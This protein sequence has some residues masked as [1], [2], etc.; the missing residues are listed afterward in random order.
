MG[1][2]RLTYEVTLKEDSDLQ[3]VQKKPEVNLDTEPAAA[4]RDT[5]AQNRRDGG[6]LTHPYAPEAKWSFSISRPFRVPE[7][8]RL[9]KEVILPVLATRGV[10]LE[11]HDASV[12]PQ[13]K[14]FWMN[15]M[16][17]ILELADI[18]I[19]VQMDQTPQ[20]EFEAVYSKTVSQTG[21][22][23]ALAVNF[24]LKRRKS[25][26]F[27]PIVVLVRNGQ[28]PD[29]FSG[30]SRRAIYYWSKSEKCSDK[31][32]ER[33]IRIIDDCIR[34]RARTVRRWDAA[35]N[36]WKKRAEGLRPRVEAL[37]MRFLER[38]AQRD[39]KVLE[40]LGGNMDLARERFK[41]QMET[42]F[43]RGRPRLE[44]RKTLLH[45][46]ALAQI[47]SSN[48]SVLAIG[49]PLEPSDVKRIAAENEIETY[50]H[51]I[52]RGEAD[53][54]QAFSETYAQQRAK[55]H[56]DLNN[57]LGLIFDQMEQESK[58]RADDKADRDPVW[59]FFANLEAFGGFIAALKFRA[60]VRHAKGE[61]YR[62]KNSGA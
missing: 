57:R 50:L 28:S 8:D 9:T 19:F 43:P 46:S 55:I 22:A 54:H 60:R 56:G 1:E 37:T 40:R 20:V 42:P 29:R 59:G 61:F 62:L 36:R 18:Q 6:E 26:V 45:Q 49:A 2:P 27:K 48:P 44:V 17:V 34:A 14:D 16:K 38:Q 21:M 51:T 12:N 23:P 32:R 39:P 13:S 35:E 33:F 53:F 41:K 30:R 3:H 31:D 25:G 52:R 11:C 15:R 7:V 5:T 10:V 24:D 58:R 4:N 47:I